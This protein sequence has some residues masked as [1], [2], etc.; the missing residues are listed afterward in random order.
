M[1]SVCDSVIF[2][3]SERSVT[4]SVAIL[5]LSLYSVVFSTKESAAIWSD[6]GRTSYYVAFEAA[7]AISQGKLGIIPQKAAEEIAKQ[8]KI[9]TIDLEEL[10]K[11]TERIGYPVLGVVKQIVRRVNDIEAGLG[12]YTHWGATTQVIALFT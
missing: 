8:C 2:G 5:I 10:R 4:Q 6:T 11:E 3:N 7:L 9:E 12:E 1:T